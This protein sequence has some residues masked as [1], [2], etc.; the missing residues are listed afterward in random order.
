M[1]AYIYLIYIDVSWMARKIPA[2]KRVTTVRDKK[3]GKVIRRT[4]TTSRGTTTHTYSKGVGQ[5]ITVTHTG[6]GAETNPANVKAGIK[7]SSAAMTKAAQTT[8]T[9]AEIATYQKTGTS[10]AQMRVAAATQQAKERSQTQVLEQ[11]QKLMAAPAQIEEP[12]IEEPKGTK[13]GGISGVGITSYT[14]ERLPSGMLKQTA[15][16]SITGRAHY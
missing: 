16:Q 7:S 10:P 6:K 8:A 5:P 14:A 2:R 9:S 12:K 1:V 13:I 4:T 3:T 11:R 15:T